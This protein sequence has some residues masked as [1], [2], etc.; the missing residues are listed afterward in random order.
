MISP[1]THCRLASIRDAARGQLLWIALVLQV[2]GDMVGA[3]DH[4]VYVLPVGGLGW[5]D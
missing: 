5:S 1:S 4:L 3:I 2:H